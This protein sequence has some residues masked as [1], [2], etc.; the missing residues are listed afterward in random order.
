MPA[1]SPGLLHGGVALA[2]NEGIVRGL[3]VLCLSWKW[4][5]SP[6]AH[7]PGPLPRPQ[8]RGC[9]AELSLRAVTVTVGSVQGCLLSPCPAP[10]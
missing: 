4:L 7:G 3:P 5:R 6:S 8:H 2:L 9:E 10:G 1:A